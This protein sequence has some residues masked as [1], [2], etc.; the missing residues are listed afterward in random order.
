MLNIIPKPNF[1]KEY[2]GKT[3]LNEEKIIFKTNNSFLDETYEIEITK[4]RITVTAKTEKAKHYAIVTLRQLK[5]ESGFVP[6]LKITDFPRFSYRAFMIDSARHMQTIDEIK[7]YIQ[8]ASELKFNYFHWHLCD[9]QGFRIESHSFPELNVV[10]S[11]RNGWGFGNKNTEKYGGFYTK[12]EIKDVVAFCKERFIEVIPEIDMP[13]HTKAILAT[14]PE[15]SCRGEKIEVETRPGIHEDIMCAGKEETFDFCFR[16]LEEVMELFPCEY[17][18]IGGDEAPK[19]RWDSCPHCQ[20]RIKEENL[21]DSE[22]LQG[23]FVNRIVSFVESKGKKAIAW[24]ESLNSDMLSKSVI[25]SDW[26]DKTH[27]CEP[28]ANEGGKL[29]IEDFYHYY[30]DY[31]YGMTPL[32]KTY[33]FNP[34]IEGLNEKGR[35]NVIGVETPIW[36]E[37]V[38]DFEKLC[39]MCFPRMMAVAETGWT[40]E[41]NKNYRLFK[42]NC[43]AKRAY[44]AS[45]GIVMTESSK[46]DPLA[47]R[48]AIDL[49]NHYKRFVTKDFIKSL[50]IKED[51]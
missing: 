51:D 39:Q 38:E 28:F 22:K 49:I 4:E 44:L 5:D 47:Y 33:T 13:G 12:E 45:K 1:I 21:A 10:G 24:N 31:P 2:S 9:D 36:T 27:K 18:H 34:Y 6:C 50:F 42:K 14:Y 16:L 15:L 29:I 11:F 32:K 8:A 46:W 35:A 40:T 37:F 48:K 43:E 17:F 7:T 26:M 23:Y 25:V 20:K 19:K 3:K 30:L 41:E